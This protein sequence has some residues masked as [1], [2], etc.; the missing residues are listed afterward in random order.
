MAIYYLGKENTEYEKCTVDQVIEYFK[1]KPE[2]Q[3]D[4]ETTGFF[5]HLSEIILL[6]FGDYD[7]QYVLS[8]SLISEE[9]I[10]KLSDN[11]LNNPNIIK[12]FQN[13]KFDIKF[14]WRHGFE[15][16]SVYDTLLAE[17]LLSAGREV[18]N[19]YYSLY[20]LAVRYC[21]VYLDKSVRGIINRYGINDR[22]INYAAEDV[23]YLS[24]IKAAQMESLVDLKLSNGN[25]QDELTVLGLENR[26]TLAFASMEYNGI[27]LNVEKWKALKAD[28]DALLT[29]QLDAVNKLVC[30]EPKLSK[31]VHYYQDLFTPAF[32]TTSINWASPQQKL[33]V[34]KHLVPALID[35]SEAE[36]S[37][38]KWS[39][40]II[41]EL[42]KL[43]KLQKLSTGFADKML[44]FV[45]KETGRIHTEYWQILSTG[46]NSSSNPNMLQ[47]PSRTELGGK[48]RECFI[49]SSGNKIVGGDLSGAEL[50]IIAE[51][52]EDPIW[53]NAFLEDKDLHSELC[54]ATFDISLADVKTY[55]PFKPD[56]KYRDVQKTIDFGLAYGMSEFKLATTIEVHTSIAKEI[57][58]KFFAIV[59]KVKEFLDGLGAAG[60]KYGFIRTAPPFGRIRWFDGYNNKSDFTRQGEIE[61]AAKNMPIQGTNADMIKLAMIYV[62][63]YIKDN[64]YPARLILQVYDE[65]Q[66]ECVEEKA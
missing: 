16:C 11:I 61:R 31:Y 39:H 43:S 36:L 12:L 56:L 24:A 33:A 4:T 26:A 20:A 13:A 10:K 6:Q 18:E 57:I 28:I 45:N 7:N 51:F 19:G 42:L 5:N 64:N 47:I 9:D 30:E 23:K 54:A 25:T 59:P 17:C 58:N 15:V 32:L 63:D 48:M 55:T 2:V 60:K 44:S 53:V 21:G 27:K 14:L 65:L 37:K 52:S 29:N 1:D 41:A 8:M 66:T 46:R 22:V 34:L 62:Y 49:A 3:V 50:R 40:P 35:T 38:Y